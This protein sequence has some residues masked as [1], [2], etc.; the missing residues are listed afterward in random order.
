MKIILGIDFGTTNSAVSYYNGNDFI[1]IP[2]NEGNMISPSVLYFDPDSLDILFGDTAARLNVKDKFSNLKRLVGKELPFEDSLSNLFK[3]NKFDNINGEIIFKVNHNKQLKKFTVNELI[4]VYINYLKKY[5][6]EFIDSKLLKKEEETDEKTNIDIVI[7]IPSYYSDIQREIIKE[8]CEK[9]NLN[10]L[11]IINEPTAAALAYSYVLYN[12]NKINSLDDDQNKEIKTEE[13]KIKDNN[14]YILV[15]DCGGGTTDLSLLYMDYSEQIYEVK[16][17]IGNNFLGGEDITQLIVDYII[18]RSDFPKKKDLNNRDYIKIRKSCENLKK[19]LS[20]NDSCKLSIDFGEFDHVIDFS[21]TQFISIITPFFNKT[22]QLIKTLINDTDD[23]LIKILN[24]VIFVGGT[25]R[26]PYFK[27]IFKEMFGKDIIINSEL[28]PDKTISLGA[29]VQ[30]ALLGGLLNDKEYSDTL[31]LD[32]IPLSLGIETMGGLMTPIISRNSILPISRTREFSNSEDFETEIEIKVYQGERKLVKDNFFLTSF[33]LTNLPE[34]EKG[35]LKI[36]VTFSI[37]SNSIITATACIN[38]SQSKIVITKN[39]IDK[40]ELDQKS[41]WSD[42]SLEAILLEAENNKLYDSEMSN[43]ILAK[44]ELYDSFKYLLSVFHEQKPVDFCLNK[45]NL[46]NNLF[47]RIFNIISNFEKYTSSQLTD[48]KDYF[49]ENWHSILFDI[50]PVFKNDN[51]LI[52]DIGGTT[53][54]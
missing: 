5:A 36:N 8:C 11:R 7:T 13:I 38:D 15:F 35:K 20:F 54:D 25:T 43:K 22:R 48:A 12:K 52:I 53:L 34:A 10:V 3:H 31:L 49:E 51:G 47:N 2:N 26:I 1:V 16:N 6:C 21:K 28:D 46:L 27:N 42:K 9:C 41:G 33:T 19:E 24:K 18:N 45:E 39:K 23:S 50:G 14:E 29:A 40:K 30:G 17:V 32:V 4:S 37:D 44:I